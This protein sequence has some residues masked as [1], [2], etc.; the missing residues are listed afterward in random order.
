MDI[1]Y[2]NGYLLQ[3]NIS[4]F[5]KN[6]RKVSRESIYG[7]VNNKFKIFH[8]IIIKL[9]TTNYLREEIYKMVLL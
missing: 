6:I 7:D 1:L 9:K 3:Y 8:K 2:F 5:N 4:K